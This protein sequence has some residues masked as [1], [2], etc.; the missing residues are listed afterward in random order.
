MTTSKAIKCTCK[1]EDQDK[2]Y[3]NSMRLHNKMKQRDASNKMWRCTIC[4]KERESGVSST[5]VS[6]VKGKKKK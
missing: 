4:K 2:I 5:S 3:G 1:H 6:N